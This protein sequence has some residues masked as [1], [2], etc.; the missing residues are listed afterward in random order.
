MRVLVT[1]GA[2]YIGS[3]TVLSL[4]EHGHQPIVVDN[5]SNSSAQSLQRV[6][7]LTGTSVEFH[8]F[9][10]CETERLSA[11]LAET[12]VDAVIHFAGLKAVGESVIKPLIYYRNNLDSTMSVIE[13]LNVTTSPA[14]PARIIFSSSATVYGDP[15]ILPYT[16][17]LSTGIEL[18]SP[19]AQSK[20]MCEE[21][22]R[23]V[24][25]AD[26]DF[27][28]ISLRYFNPIGAHPSGEIGEDP[29]QVPNNLAPYITQVAVGRLERLGVFGNDY[30]TR[31]GTGVRDY[32]HVM[33]V[34]EGHI[35]AL[36]FMAPGFHAV[37][38]G[39]GQGTSVMELVRAF[40][41]ASGL[42]IPY[43]ITP[44]RDGDIAEY[45]AS[46]DLAANAFGWRARR[47]IDDACRDA[48]HWQSR[49][50]EGFQ[51]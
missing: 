3:H 46:A 25:H 22:L 20:Y 8:E 15:G 38:L 33:D 24:C 6:E 18:A 5:L 31:D 9:D 35:A 45:F 2:G 23:D 42:K 21:I 49:N 44:R 41:T 50:P 28:A 1:G 27:Q 30:P 51:D 26:P 47:S 16:E 43:E 11:L 39:T 7:K 40:E 10:V 32:I 12:P 19:Y 4:I 17:S 13:A 36:N 14:Q 48:W 37:N 29:T 34:A